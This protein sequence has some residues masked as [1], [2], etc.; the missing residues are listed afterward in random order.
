MLDH[1]IVGLYLCSLLFV[2]LY[3]RS[4]NSDIRHYGK[5]TPQMQGKTWLLLATIFTNSVGGG[6]VFGLSERVF[7][8]NLAYFYAIALTILIDIVLAFVL[9]PR[10]TKHYGVISIG[11]IFAKYY[12]K[13]GRVFIGISA[14]LVSFGYVAIQIA[15]SS[16]IFQ[17]VLHI[18]YVEGVI[19]SYLVLI[20]YTALGGLRSIIMT[21]F[22]QFIAIILF[23]PIVSFVGIYK[24]GL[25]NFIQAIPI[26]KYSI[27]YLWQDTIMLF[28]S[29]S[30]LGCYPG[31]IQRA[32]MT[33]D[34]KQ[35]QKAILG[36]SAIYFIFLCFI[37]INGLLAYI[38][39][40][41]LND[42]NMA[43]LVLLDQL[44]PTGL[45]G[46]V[47]LGFLAAVMS[48]ADSELNIASI[49]LT[50][51]VLTPM[52]RLHDNKMILLFT[53]L[54]TLSIGIFA[55]FLALSFNNPVDLVL[56]VAGFWLPVALVPLI[57]CLYE[58]IICKAGLAI[59]ALSGI[60]AFFYWQMHFANQLALKSA[61]VGMLANLLV[62]SIIKL[63]RKA[64]GNN[65][66]HI[67]N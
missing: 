25:N 57:A 65:I 19:L 11:E 1:I 20:T 2:G 36:K 34:K 22:L 64:T 55:I 45:R 6:T 63:L 66:Q 46:L 48:T 12:G 54:I 62:F 35:T 3:N 27:S 7:S 61:F 31:F 52:F 18:N 30:F 33:E 39:S 53:Q 38:H 24:L 10:I 17:Y 37:A 50:N 42:G 32:F 43:I 14:T 8:Y 49:S 13:F 67:S 59:S 5:I 56:F 15:V 4:K 23:I 40:P 51:D 26:E 28:F 44:V 58:V 29:F 41:N 9:V 47:I 21:N 16:R 60:C